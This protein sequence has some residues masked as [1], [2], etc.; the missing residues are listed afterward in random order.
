MVVIKIVFL[1][2]TKQ[3]SEMAAKY[4]FYFSCGLSLA[5]ILFHLL[6]CASAAPIIAEHHIVEERSVGQCVR[7]SALSQSGNVPIA[8]KEDGQIR[9]LFGSKEV[10]RILDVKSQ[11]DDS[12]ELNIQSISTGL[13][14]AVTKNGVVKGVSQVDLNASEGSGND[15][16]N[17]QYYTN[18]IMKPSSQKN[19]YRITVPRNNLTECVISF[20]EPVPR[21][22]PL[23]SSAATDIFEVIR[24]RC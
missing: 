3:Y 5:V 22:K 13:F 12:R 16:S 9:K 10:F 2:L 15:D 20:N 7:I 21:C 1:L 11:L 17:S 24:K 23:T 19:I 4:N 18:F 6:V 14:L 8:T